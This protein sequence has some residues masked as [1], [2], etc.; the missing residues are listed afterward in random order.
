MLGVPIGTDEF[1]QADTARRLEDYADD[2]DALDYFSVHQRYI[3]L[4]KCINQ[5]P[6]FLQRVIDLHLCSD[7]FGAFDDAITRAVMRL[8]G[9]AQVGDDFKDQV[10]A[11]RGLRVQL[12][13]GGIRHLARTSVRVRSLQLARDSVARYLTQH[14]AEAAACEATFARWRRHELPM[15]QIAPPVAAV[16]EDP[17]AAPGAA[18]RDTVTSALCRHVLGSIPGGAVTEVLVSAVPDTTRSRS[19]AR[20]EADAGALAAD[21]VLHSQTLTALATSTQQS[22]MR[23]QLAAQVLSS[24][25]PN[26]DGGL[27]QMVPVGNLGRSDSKFQSMLRLRFGVPHLLPP[28]QFRCNCS[29][30]GG[31]ADNDFLA[32]RVFA[33]ADD[34]T[35]RASFADEPCHALSCRRRWSRITYRH[36]RIVN[37]MHKVL[38]GFAQVTAIT[39]EPQVSADVRGDLRVVLSSG[40]QHVLDLG[41]T[42]PA[43]PAR[44]NGAMRTHK[45]P[46]AAAEAYDKIKQDK[47][48]RAGVPNAVPFIVETGGRFSESTR[49]F[50]DEVLVDRAQPGDLLV[51][52]K[53]FRQIC[54]NLLDHNAYCMSKLTQELAIPDLAA[55]PA[56]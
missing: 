7:A 23:K 19:A 3:L 54:W 2:V 32:A 45:T 34:S 20:A 47:Y 30:H 37:V 41:I 1:V 53:L 56:A 46:G 55:A 14:P 44:V 31:P 15:T 27:M 22:S 11:L 8:M 6:V 21:L 52:H 9:V 49:R 39:L 16:G 33:A 36:K 10:A 28:G 4:Q 25:C 40:V 51:A 5:R 18:A 29:A 43:T 42:C 26:S 48:D 50:V 35:P 38:R 24:S 12:S 17:E 13:G